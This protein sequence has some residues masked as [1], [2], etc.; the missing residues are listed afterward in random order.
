MHCCTPYCSPFPQSWSHSPISSSWVQYLSARSSYYDR[1]RTS[2]YH[3]TSKRSFFSWSSSTCKRLPS[4]WVHWSWASFWAKSW[5][6]EERDWLGLVFHWIATTSRCCPHAP[7]S[8]VGSRRWISRSQRR[9]TRLVRLIPSTIMWRNRWGP[10]PR[11]SSGSSAGCRKPLC[12][13]SRSLPWSSHFS[14]SSLRKRHGSRGCSSW[15]RSCW[16][17]AHFRWWSQP[18]PCTTAFFCFRG[19]AGSRPAWGRWSALRIFSGFDGPTLACS[20]RWL[21]PNL[22][23]CLRRIFY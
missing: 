15:A 22:K 9:S 5:R 6:S 19:N 23:G 21:L 8:R 14:C 2:Q 1:D 3:T 18:S 11:S 7:W 20:S 17:W 16:L 10:P 4:S 12:N 13:F